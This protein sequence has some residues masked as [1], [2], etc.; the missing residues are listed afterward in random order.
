MREKINRL[1][2]GVLNEEQPVLSVSPERIDMAIRRGEVLKVPLQADSLNSV[3]LKGLAWSDSIRVRVLRSSFGGK[4]NQIV[5]EADGR[6]LRA[7]DRIEG[8]LALVTNGGE[9]IVPFLFT[10]TDGAAGTTLSSLKTIEDFALIAKAEPESALRIF[11]YKD[12]VSA[13]FMQDLKLRSLYNAFRMGPDRASAMEEFLVASG[14]KK[15]ALVRNE[16]GRCEIVCTDGS[17]EGRIVLVRAR[18]GYFSLAV[19]ADGAFLKLEKRSVSASEFIGSSFAYLFRIDPSRLH[20]GRNEGKISFYS[21]TSE[22]SV[23]V[24]VWR[25]GESS[26]ASAREQKTTRKKH[27]AEYVSLRAQY[28]LTGRS[29]KSL[30]GQ[31]I[32]ELKAA[33]EGAEQNTELLLLEAEASMFAGQTDRCRELL[34]SVGDA[35]RENRQHGIYEYLLYEA[36]RALLPE[37]EEKRE[38]TMLLLRKY[39]EEAKMYTLLPRYL[40]FRPELLKRDPSSLKLFL[41]EEYLN[42]N[43][44][45]YLYAAFAQLYEQYPDL[46]SGLGEEELAVLRYS[47][48]RGLPGKAAAAVYTQRAG[49]LR[50]YTDLHCRLLAELYDKEPSAELLTAVCRSLIRRD[51]RTEAAHLWY[52]KGISADIRLTGLCE[53]VIYSMPKEQRTALPREILLYFAYDNRL[54]DRSRAVLY[55]NICRFRKKE[56]TLWEEYRKQLLPFT[57]EQLLKGR[58]NRHLAVL[59]RKVLCKEIIDRRLATVLPAVL[60]ARRIRTDSDAVR[61]VVMISPRLKEE[62]KYLL[63]KKTAYVPVQAEDAVFLF[64]DSYGNR[65][66]DVAW[67]EEQVCSMP[68]LLEYCEDLVPDGPWQILKRLDRIAA[69]AE[70]M[71]GGRLPAGEVRTVISAIEEGRLSESFTEQLL[72]VLLDHPEDS[73]NYLA[74]C[75]DDM[76]RPGQRSKLLKVLID[77]GQTARAWELM[78]EYMI[79]DLGTEHLKKLCS[80]MIL[81]ELFPEDP[82]LLKLSARVF[83]EGGADPVILDYLCERFNGGEDE[84]YRLLKASTGSGCQTED[85]EE[86]LT[87]QMLFTGKTQRLK[88]LFARLRERS[89]APEMLLRAC[90]TEFSAEYVLD[91]KEPGKDI[92]LYL[93]TLAGAAA[94]R[95]RIPVIYRLALIRYYASLNSLGEQQKELAEQILPG[96]LDEGLSFPYYKNLAQFIPVPQE[97]LDKESVMFRGDRDVSYEI[98]MR[99]LPE[100]TEFRT[101]QLRNMF[102]DLFVRQEILFAG[103]SW[104][105]EIRETGGS[106]VLQRGEIRS[107]EENSGTEKDGVKQHSRFACLNS[108]TKSLARKDEK[109]LRAEM[110][111]F[112]AEEDLAAELFGLQ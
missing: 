57:L 29:D 46:I 42:G 88:V 39:L 41:H 74:G 73:L 79:G 17:E 60:N 55:E 67:K 32:R 94:D 22:F 90:I 8:K 27:Y 84:M 77:G 38:S 12:F 78:E 50:N 6:H 76:F 35:V 10:V 87:G 34:E 58:V 82:M 97:V 33:G 48:S 18:E 20:E 36:V 3:H 99:I 28:E 92:F 16:T 44:S 45:P 51:Q 71:P 109:T 31:M 23:P 96:L 9:R 24:T 49:E 110:E 2:R 111:S 30:P 72:T 13:P 26:D 101:E 81:E 43:R 54:D 83:R 106:E 14:A 105:Y 61:S 91:D 103:E 80:R 15:P 63:D 70:T 89:N 4:R 66:A 93:E 25:Q 86:R 64:E 1:A 95:N 21:Q 7:G 62:E 108:M 107:S 59:Y 102:L 85:L 47:L 104:E 56:Q 100:E 11:E 75:P 69:G 37:R 53:Y 98:R 5:L 52:L 112:A 65:F 19:R 40:F 68:E